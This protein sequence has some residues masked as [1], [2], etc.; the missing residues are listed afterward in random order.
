MKVGLSMRSPSAPESGQLNAF[1]KVMYQW[2]ELHPYNAV[3]A[4]RIA[5]ELRADDLREAMRATYRALGIGI[6][7]IAADRRSYRYEVDDTPPLEVIDGGDDPMAVLKT[8]FARELNTPFARPRCRPMRFTAI[9]GDRGD[10]YVCVGYDHWVADSVASRLILRHILGRY[11]DLDLPENERMPVLYPQTYRR[12]LGRRLG[13]LR[14]VRGAIGAIGRFFRR[15][16]M[17][18]VPYSSVTH[19][20][21]GYQHCTTEPG[22]VERLRQ[23]ARSHGATVHDV[24][25]AALSRAIA[26]HLPRRAV[27]GGK[28]SMAM[29]TIVDIRG[30]AEADLGESLGA[31]LSYYTVHY[32]VRPEASL[33]DLCEGVAA[34]T[35]PIKTHRRYLDAV[36]NMKLFSKVWPLLNPKRQTHFSRLVLPMTAGVSNVVIRDRWMTQPGSPIL[37]YYR[38][39]PT[40]PMLPLTM[41]V[42]T[43]GDRMNFGI[44][45]RQ[46]GFTE[47]RLRGIVAMLLD[48]LNNPEQ[49]ALDGQDAQPSDAGAAESHSF[50]A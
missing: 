14:M 9:T 3:H 34:L 17:C 2:S 18:R 44:T 36:A 20:A 42:T 39:S 15:R 43:F 5:G 19:M 40:G 11:L 7:E 50:A 27:A 47:A 38:G 49:S 41:A 8:Q 37:G 35:G 30:D 10:H 6:V 32:P 45:Y 28:G 24:I 1:Q 46:T 22:S 12:V 26:E 21:V 16:A 33:G 23:F 31:F 13:R 4:Y 25:L 48:Q 29:G